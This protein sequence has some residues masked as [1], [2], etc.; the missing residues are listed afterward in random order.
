[1]F[2]EHMVFYYTV[3]YTASGVMIEFS[4]QQTEVEFVDVGRYCTSQIP[5][6][7][8]FWP[9]LA[10]KKCE[11]HHL[12]LVRFWKATFFAPCLFVS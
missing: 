10:L 12:Q 3:F 2:L 1:M 4:L 5:T 11:I 7:I 8:T 9:L 6:C